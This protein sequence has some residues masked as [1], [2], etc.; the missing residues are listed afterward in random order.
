MI[1]IHHSSLFEIQY[2]EHISGWHMQM[3]QMTHNCCKCRDCTSTGNEI[4]KGSSL[5]WMFGILIYNSLWMCVRIFLHWLRVW[6][7]C[8]YSSLPLSAWHGSFIFAR[9]FYL[10]VSIWSTVETRACVWHIYF[11]A[12]SF[13]Y[14]F[15]IPCQIDH[16]RC[17]WLGHFLIVNGMWRIISYTLFGI[18]IIIFQWKCET[19]AIHYIVCTKGQWR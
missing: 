4:S 11:K 16:T 6:C 15:T 17:I 5:V 18:P 12:F 7:I 13:I 1:T 14:F 19:F 9:F 2:D 3:L 8:V 10:G